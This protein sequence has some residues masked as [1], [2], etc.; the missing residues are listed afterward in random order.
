MDYFAIGGKPFLPNAEQCREQRAEQS[1]EQRA[2]SREQRAESREQRAESRE[3]RAESRE[4]RA[5]SRA[6][7]SRLSSKHVCCGGGRI[8]RRLR[9]RF[10]PHIPGI[11]NPQAEPEE[12]PEPALCLSVSLSFSLCVFLSGAEPPG[13]AD[14]RRGSV[15]A[16]PA[17]L[18]S[19][20]CAAQ[21]PSPGDCSATN[22]AV[23]P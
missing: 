3:Q 14:S 23:W 13:H 10:P 22:P 21:E 12:P 17:T 18:P 5:E 1:R 4:Q 8:L 19:P 2:E 15:K 6:E 7:Q 9:S 20:R 11:F 16:T